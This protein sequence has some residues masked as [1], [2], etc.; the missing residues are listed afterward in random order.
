M[1]EKLLKIQEIEHMMAVV[2]DGAQLKRL[3]DVLNQCLL[4]E[5]DFEM[6]LGAF[7]SNEEVLEAFLCAK[8]N[9]KDARNDHSAIMQRR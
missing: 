4:S 1:R 7:G 5:D 6:A 9:L 3:H 8:K 2:L